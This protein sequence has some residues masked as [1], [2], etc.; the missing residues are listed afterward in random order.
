MMTQIPTP[1]RTKGQ[2]VQGEFYPLQKPEL[3]ALRQSK[4]INNAAYVHFALRSENPFCDRPIEVIPKE[5]ALRWIIPESS[6]YEAFAKLKELGIVT[7]RSGRV[8]IEW[9]GHSQ[10]ENVSENPES[11][12]DSQNEFWD[13]RMDSEISEAAHIDRARAQTLQ[14]SQ[15]LQTREEVEEKFLSEEENRIGNQ[16]GE[17]SQ[18]KNESQPEVRQVEAPIQEP[19][20]PE[21]KQPEVR[22]VEAPI[23]EPAKPEVKQP[24]VKA[25]AEDLAK[26]QFEAAEASQENQA[27]PETEAETQEE[28]LEVPP[29]VAAKLEALGVNLNPWNESKFPEIPD[30]LYN[31]LKKLE[32]P[33]DRQ[34]REAITTYDLSQAYGAAAHVEKSW[35]SIKN[36]RSIFLYQLPRQSKKRTQPT[37]GRKQ[38]LDAEFLA[39]YETAIADGTVQDISPEQLSRDGHN[40]PLVRLNRPDPITGAPYQIEPWQRVRDSE[41]DYATPEQMKDFFDEMREQVEQ[42]KANFKSQWRGT[43]SV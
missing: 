18:A 24:E 41:I 3:L 7:I 38:K 31:K 39:W 21:V 1:Q 8:V 15:T 13:L 37:N 29:E 4:L 17:D 42:I 23:Q 22:Q 30:D 20:K 11:I 26:S 33:L 9:G 14:T 43:A 12:L 16:I 10:Q 6:V 25:E 28:K 2:K 27:P 40:Q 19:A 34:V 32:I 36:P 35:E 5:F